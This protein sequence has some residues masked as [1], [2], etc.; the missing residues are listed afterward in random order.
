MSNHPLDQETTPTTME[1][2]D[3]TFSLDMFCADP[4]EAAPRWESFARRFPKER[5]MILTIRN[6]RLLSMFNLVINP[7]LGTYSEGHW[8]VFCPDGSG[9]TISFYLDKRVEEGN[10]APLTVILGVSE[11]VRDDI[12]ASFN[13]QIKYTKLVG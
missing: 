10:G 11:D 9:N 5:R 7:T 3:R 13:S 1:I 4:E 12:Y 8:D 2:G 6:R